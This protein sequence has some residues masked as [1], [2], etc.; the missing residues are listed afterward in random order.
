MA[1][2]LPVALRAAG[3]AFLLKIVLQA[4]N[5]RHFIVLQ[6]GLQ[7][8]AFA[9]FGKVAKQAKAGNIGKRFNILHLP[10][11]LAQFV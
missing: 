9:H 11:Y 10:K 7:A 2:A 5:N 3:V 8:A 4:L 6:Y 1:I